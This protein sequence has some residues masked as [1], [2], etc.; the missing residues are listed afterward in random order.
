M[1]DKGTY[2]GVGPGSCLTSTLLSSARP[3]MRTTERARASMATLNWPSA[4]GRSERSNSN[5]PRKVMSA[6][7]RLDSTLK[8]FH[9]HDIA[10]KCVGETRNRALTFVVTD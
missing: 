7:N 9:R 2:V 3:V 8:L 5:E 1:W 10:R 6:I 4:R